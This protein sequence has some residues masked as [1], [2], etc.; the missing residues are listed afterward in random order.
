M[1]KWAQFDWKWAWSKLF[2]HTT[3]TTIIELV[4]S[5]SRDGPDT[6][7]YVIQNKKPKY[8]VRVH[9][10]LWNC[11]DSVHRL[12]SYLQVYIEP[13]FVW[14]NDCILGKSGQIANPRWLTPYHIIVYAHVYICESINCEH[15]KYSQFAINRYSQLKT[16][17]RYAVFLTCIEQ[18]IFLTCNLHVTCL[19]FACC[20][21][22]MH[23][24]CYTYFNMHTTCT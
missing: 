4:D 24:A 20:S 9:F 15:K 17:L 8:S 14:F 18:V 13:P 10:K 1:Q 19:L 6:P 11:H 5:I 23:C 16:D 22:Y 21:C 7:I 12:I 2:A 3:H